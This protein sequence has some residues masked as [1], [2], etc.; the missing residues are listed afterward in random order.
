V[1]QRRHDRD[2]QS[3]GDSIEFIRFVIPLG[4]DMSRK[5]GEIC[6]RFEEP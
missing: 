5:A 2:E 1:A 6:T 3:L 4:L